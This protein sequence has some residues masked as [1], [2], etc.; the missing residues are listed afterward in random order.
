M[1]L[2]G[3]RETC[4]AAGARLCLEGEVLSSEARTMVSSQRCP[5]H[6]GSRFWLDADE[7]SF[8]LNCPESRSVAA[9]ER[10]WRLKVAPVCALRTKPL[11]VLCCADK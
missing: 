6:F 7:R 2:E 5:L 1:D 9:G 4:F 11:S 8:I 10:F 3:A